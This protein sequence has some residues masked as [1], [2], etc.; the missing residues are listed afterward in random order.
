MEPEDKPHHDAQGGSQGPKYS[1]LPNTHQ[2]MSQERWC[3][4]IQWPHEGTFSLLKSLQ[5]DVCSL[6]FLALKGNTFLKI[7]VFIFYYLIRVDA[8]YLISESNAHIKQNRNI[9]FS[10]QKCNGLQVITLRMDSPVQ[11]PWIP[12]ALT[13]LVLIHIFSLLCF[14]L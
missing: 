10:I 13:H 14:A 7:I 3:F 9:L 11:G 5:F 1:H 4:A 8:G 12:V 2:D 6:A